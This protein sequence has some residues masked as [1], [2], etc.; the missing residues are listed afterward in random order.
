MILLMSLKNKITLSFFISAFIIAILA[1]FEYLSFIEIKKEIR[2][3]EITATIS[4]KSLQLRRHEKNYLL[5]SPEKASQESEAVHTY[6]NQFKDILARNPNIDKTDQLSLRSSFNEYERSF[7]KIESSAQRLSAAFES[8]RGFFKKKEAFYDLVKATFLERPSQ[9][10]DALANAFHLP[11]SHMLV[12]GLVEL[13][14]DIIT[15]RKTGEDI[16]IISKDIDKIAREKVESVIRVSQIA[17]LIFFPLF[18]IV[19]IGMLFFISTNVVRRLML[20]IN[21]VEKTGKGSYPHLSIPSSPGNVRDEVGV[22]IEKF[23]TMED[24][25]ALHEEELERKNRE[26]AQSKK[27]A[28]IGTLASGVA[29]ELNNPLNNIYLSAQVLSKEAGKSC[30]ADVKEAVGDIVGQTERVKRIVSDLLEF[31]RGR[32]LQLKEIELGGLITDSYRHLGSTRNLSSVRFSIKSDPS[33]VSVAADEGQLEQVFI[34]LFTNALDAMQDE[35]GL[36]VTVRQESQMVFIT[37]KDTGKGMPRESLEKIF[38]PFFTTKD[39]GTGLGLAIVYNI[40][41]KH[42]GDIIVESSEGMGTMFTITLPKG[43]RAHGI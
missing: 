10:A 12:T 33:Q 21:V 17:I 36:T 29:H 27:L 43:N 8:N 15:L 32:E 40:I 4:R 38:E 3:L 34:N 1:A 23:N 14:A 9:S 7:S 37:V 42:N 26:L 31:A 25:L 13:D 30:S 41:Q 28:A 19:G 35:G 11:R 24:Q 5:Y 2:Y 20:L 18:F 6:L 39:K 22:L 16:M